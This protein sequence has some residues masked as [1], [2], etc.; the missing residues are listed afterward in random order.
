MAFIVNLCPNPSFES[1]LQGWTELPGTVIGQDS[2]FTVAGQEAMLVVTDGNMP[3]EGVFGPAVT[4]TGNATGA[5]SLSLVGAAGDVTV[6]AVANP[7]GVVLA[8]VPV[9]LTGVGYQRATLD[10]L[11]LVAGQQLYVLVQTTTAQA[12]SFWV[13]A[14]QYEPVSPASP[15]IDGDQPNCIWLGTPGLSA[16]EQPFEHATSASGT[17]FLDGFAIPVTAGGAFPTSASG[18]MT[19]A[20][21]AAPSTGDPVAAFADF[22]V[23]E[24]TDPD[25]AMTYAGQSNAGTSSGHTGYVRNYGSFHAPLDYPVSTGKNLWYRAAYLAAGF[26]F[27]NVAAGAAQNINLVQTEMVP[28]TGS[29]PVPS[30]YDPPRALHSIIKP[31][32]LNFVTNPSF[33][34]STNHWSDVGTGTVSQDATKSVGNV[35]EYFGFEFT[36]G[37]NSGKVVVHANGDGVSTILSDLIVGDMYTV[38]AFIQAGAGLSDILLSCPGGAAAS[39]QTGVPYGGDELSDIGFGQGPYG[40]IAAGGADMATGSWFRPN[41]SFRAESSSVI[42][43]ATAVTATD[44]SNPSAFWIDAVLTEAGEILGDYFDGGYGA[45]DY[46]DYQWENGGT[47]GE[48]RSYYYEQLTAKQA[49]ITDALARHIPI[50]LTAETPEFFTPYTQ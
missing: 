8:S 48:S 45:P 3:G 24:L 22:A 5:V 7:G 38:S 34:T 49:A 23:C 43:S 1:S 50:G 42:L 2:T 12:L 47:P 19:L 11:A 4:N 26:W 46:L 20:G 33:E 36:A 16:S 18:T 44:F 35:A 41:F 39:N 28:F 29:A 15:Y 9:T 21:D 31:T 37:S 40:G 13:D 30:A 27:T 25:P 17:M 10:N 14:V 32:R 6:S